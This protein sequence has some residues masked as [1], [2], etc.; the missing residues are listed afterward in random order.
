MIKVTI[1]L[2]VLTLAVLGAGP[3]MSGG[4]LR[5]VA[6]METARAAH[7]MTTLPDGRVLVVGGFGETE[8]RIAGTVVYQP[9]TERFVSVRARFT[10]RHSHSAT[11]LANGTVL[12]VGGFDSNGGYLDQAEVFDP[13]DGTVRP[14]G[15]L[16]NARADHTATLLNDGTVLIAGGV[17][18][19]WSFL[20]SAERYDPRSG[21][22]SVTGP[23]TAARE[24]HVATRLRDGRVLVTGGHAGRQ[25][26]MQVRRTA[27]IHDP[28]LGAFGPSD[29]MT[30][31]RHKHEAVALGDGRVLVL[32]GADERDSRGVYSST[33][34]FDPATGRFT[35]HQPMQ[36]PRY[37]HA[38]TAITLPDGRILIAGG[39]AQP[40]VYQP[41]TGRFHLMRT[42]A[43]LRGQF[44]ATA[45]LPDGRVLITGGYGQRGGPTAQAWVFQEQ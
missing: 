23:M 25:A 18:T 4:E 27:E 20:L 14:V 39:A 31:R 6:S 22:F 44:S 42:T 10:V 43:E 45:R 38:G 37:K 16:R 8:G 11:L 33:E 5:A 2:G 1:A 41:D 36:L 26:Q 40:E 9:A 21:T 7:T 17:G 30:I 34:I 3:T 19:G 29:S 12:I 32:G 13:R 28:R 24:G 35:L 15:R